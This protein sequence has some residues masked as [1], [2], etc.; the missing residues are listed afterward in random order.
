VCGGFTPAVPRE[1]HYWVLFSNMTD[2]SVAPAAGQFFLG[3]S[4]GARSGVEALDAALAWA[5]GIMSRAGLPPHGIRISAEEL[6]AQAMVLPDRE[7]FYDGLD[8]VFKKHRQ[9]AVA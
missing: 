3:S 8:V 2:L 1:D 5:L 9:Q 6:R 7:V 4:Q